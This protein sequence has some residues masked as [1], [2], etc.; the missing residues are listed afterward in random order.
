MMLGFAAL[1]A[2]AAGAAVVTVRTGPTASAPVALIARIAGARTVRRIRMMTSMRHRGGQPASWSRR[3]RPAR[4]PVPIIASLRL[5][6]EGSVLLAEDYHKAYRV[7]YY[8]E[9]RLVIDAGS[10][11]RARAVSHGQ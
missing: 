2:T 8:S 7:I 1:T 5:I 11:R 6:T 9:S 10:V 4:L 3:P